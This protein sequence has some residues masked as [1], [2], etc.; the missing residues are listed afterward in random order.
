MKWNKLYKKKT[1][2]TRHNHRRIIES[3]SITQMID[4]RN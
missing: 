3:W 1:S 2:L 4:N